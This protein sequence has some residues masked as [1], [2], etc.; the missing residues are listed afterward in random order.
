MLLHCLL[1]LLQ[2]FRN[3]LVNLSRQFH[4]VNPRTDDT[5]NGRNLL[6]HVSQ[7]R[8]RVPNVFYIVRPQR[9]AQLNQHIKAVQRSF[10]HLTAF[11]IN[12]RHYAIA[13]FPFDR[14]LRRTAIGDAEDVPILVAGGDV[15]CSRRFRPRE[16][17]PSAV[18]GFT[19]AYGVLEKLIDLI[20]DRP[21]LL[22]VVGITGALHSQPTGLDKERFQLIQRRL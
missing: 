13:D 16:D 18:A 20:T 2:V 17:E 4:A 11:D 15:R 5:A 10:E 22:C 14:Y 8:Q 9:V 6:P 3:Y 12:L 21:S 7:L 19:Q 1:G